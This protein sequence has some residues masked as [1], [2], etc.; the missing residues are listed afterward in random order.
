MGRDL[1][2]EYE[3]MNRDVIVMRGAFE[4]TDATEFRFELRDGVWVR[5]GGERGVDDETR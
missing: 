1:F 5:A 4:N 3:G 2:V